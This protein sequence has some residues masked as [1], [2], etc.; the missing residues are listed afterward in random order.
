MTRCL[1]NKLSAVHIINVLFYTMHNASLFC[2]SFPYLKLSVL[3]SQF[4][5]FWLQPLALLHHLSHL[6]VLQSQAA[7]LGCWCVVCLGGVEH[8]GSFSRVYVILFRTNA[9]SFIQERVC[10]RLRSKF[11]RKVTTQVWRKTKTSHECSF[12]CGLSAISCSVYAEWKAEKG[13]F[14]LPMINVTL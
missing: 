10:V 11:N 7:G 3:I 2:S 5:H 1:C 4:A 8:G 6:W 12:E 13:G 9:K 14:K